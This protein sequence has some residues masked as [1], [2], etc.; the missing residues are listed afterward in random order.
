VNGKRVAQVIKFGK[1]IKNSI[2]SFRQNN[3]K[4][5]NWQWNHGSVGFDVN[6]SYNQTVNK[7]VL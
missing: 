7:N 1:D 4:M 6:T 5:K 2:I 3:G